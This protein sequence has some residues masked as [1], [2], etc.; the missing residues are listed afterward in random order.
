[1]NDKTIIK[2]LNGKIEFTN[3]LYFDVITNSNDPDYPGIDI[4]IINP[5]QRQTKTNPRVVIEYNRNDNQ[6]QI[7]IWSDP[8]N[9]DYTH[10]ILFTKPV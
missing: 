7:L 6:Y 4:E 8:E 2:E 3:G 9:E 1:M 10:K 5:E